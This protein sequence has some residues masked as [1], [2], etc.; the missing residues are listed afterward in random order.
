MPSNMLF[1]DTLF[2]K[3]T[4]E[5]STKAAIK[6][7]LNYQFMLN[8]QLQ[9][10]FYNLGAENFNEVEWDNLTQPI[11]ASIGEAEGK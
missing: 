9:Y 6:K 4:E 10:S 8:E 7:I 11:F 5:D 2:P 3:I 1:M